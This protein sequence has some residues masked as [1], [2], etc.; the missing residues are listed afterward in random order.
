MTDS[1]FVKFLNKY[2]P[3]RYER[4][5]KDFIS[6]IKYYD[7][8]DKFIAM[9]TYNHVTFKRQISMEETS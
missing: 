6:Y 4:T 5:D 9:V 3:K 2:K 8:Q 1:E 7:N